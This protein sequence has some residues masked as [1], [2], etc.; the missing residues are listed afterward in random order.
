VPQITDQER[1]VRE[2]IL[3]FVSKGPLDGM[4]R[5]AYL[6]CPRCGYYVLK[7]AGYDECPCGNIAI[8]SDMLRVQVQDT[9]ESE[10]EC[11]NAVRRGGR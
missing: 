8:D 4:W 3:V 11:F 2:N 5:C 1:F 9:P 6:K 7:G 10:V